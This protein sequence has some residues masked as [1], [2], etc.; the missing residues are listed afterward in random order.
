M[1]VRCVR[2]KGPSRHVKERG[3]PP[4]PPKLNVVARAR[5]ASRRCEKKRATFVK[6]LLSPPFNI[7]LKGGRGEELPCAVVLRWAFFS[8][9]PGTDV[10]QFCR[11]FAKGSARGLGSN[12][13]AWCRGAPGGVRDLLRHGS[14]LDSRGA[15]LHAREGALGQDPDRNPRLDRGPPRSQGRQAAE[16]RCHPAEP[17]GV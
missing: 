9:A 16:S 11:E 6:R 13:L 7:E 5:R 4:V 14:P 3:R 15:R 17:S 10:N 1:R 12:T 2:K 8:H